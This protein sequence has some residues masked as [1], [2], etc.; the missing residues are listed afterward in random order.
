MSASPSPGQPNADGTGRAKRAAA[1]VPG[2]LLA[3]G[4]AS[5]AG[6]V[7]AAGF[8]LIYDADLAQLVA[9]HRDSSTGAPK[10]ALLVLGPVVF[11]LVTWR[12]GVVGALVAL[13]GYGI[14]GPWLAATSPLHDEPSVRLVC[15]DGT[16]SLQFL[17]AAIIGIGCCLVVAPITLVVRWIWRHY[18]YPA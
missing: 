8:V 7:T 17:A 14:I 15:C 4:L 11:A 3:L 5:L 1:A 16:R 6:F 12:L 13:V 10:L 18:R 9:G 2:L